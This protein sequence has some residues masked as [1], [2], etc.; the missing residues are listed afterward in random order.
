MRILPIISRLSAQCPLLVS[1]VEPAKSLMALSDEEVQNAIP[2]AFV[3][4]IKEEA[5]R[6][7]T[8]GVTMQRMPRQ[9][10]VI[11]ASANSDGVDEPLEDV[12]DQV[13]SALTGWWPDSAHEPIEYVSGEVIE[14]STRLIWWRDIFITYTFNRG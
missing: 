10:G 2:V 7:Q 1:R 3:Y 5:T 4:P 8:V 9:F 13:R 14:V 11:I 6:S 12:R